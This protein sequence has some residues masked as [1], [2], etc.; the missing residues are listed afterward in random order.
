MRNVL[1]S[2]SREQLTGIG[3]FVLSL[4]LLILGISGGGESRLSESGELPVPGIRDFVKPPVLES[5]ISGP[6]FSSYWRGYD[7]FQMESST[8]PP[9]PRIG[10]M[11]PHESPVIPPILRPHPVLSVYNSLSLGRHREAVEQVRLHEPATDLAAQHA[12]RRRAAARVRLAAPARDVLLHAVPH[13]GGRW[14][15]SSRLLRGCGWT[16]V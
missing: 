13:A 16:W 6:E 15:R 8:R 11:F 9:V 2:F 4:L 7:V 14:R 3:A 12:A 5:R 1:K 10:M